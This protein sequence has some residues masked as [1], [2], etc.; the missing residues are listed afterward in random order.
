M[1]QVRLEC[2]KLKSIR[3]RNSLTGTAIDGPPQ[4][5]PAWILFSGRERLDNVQV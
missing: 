1:I 3:N 4:S 5:H 2:S